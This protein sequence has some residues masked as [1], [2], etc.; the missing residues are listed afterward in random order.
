[1][2]DGKY[3]TAA[4]VSA[5]IDMALTLAAAIAGEQTA[6][7]IQLLIEYDPQPPF[8]AGSVAKAPAEIVESIRA[9]PRLHRHRKPEGMR[10]MRTNRRDRCTEILDLID[11]CLADVETDRLASQPTRPPT[12]RSHHNN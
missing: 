2:L 1:M 10:A 11:R 5:G 6:K 12:P 7:A 9:D 8:D 3:V 4:G